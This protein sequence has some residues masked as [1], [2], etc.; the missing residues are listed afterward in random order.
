MKHIKFIAL[1][2][3]TLI[4]T[5]AFAAKQVVVYNWSE[6]IPEAVVEKFTEETGIKVIYS[7]YE[8][9]EVMYSKLQL[10]KNSG[11]DVIV[12]SAYYVSK[13]AKEKML[14]PLDKSKISHFK[15]L[16]PT[17]L[18][19]EFDP[20][21]QYSAPYLWGSTGIGVNSSEIDPATITSW[22]QL[23]DKK[24]AKQLLVTDDL[25]E[26]FH[27][28]LVLNGHSPN[29]T[30]PEEI[31]QAYELLKTLMPNVLTF[32]SDAPREP[33]LAGDV[34]LGMIWSGEAVMA[35]EEE[36]A[37]QY[38]YPSEGAIFWVDSFAIPAGAKNVDE[39]HAFID[40]MLRADN[41]AACVEEIGYATANKDALELVEEDTRNNPAIFPSEE[42]IKAGYF[43]NDVGD[44]VSI[45][46]QYWELL[47][48]G[49]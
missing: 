20:D 9:N 23:F 27:I 35:Q 43:Q 36:P 10:Q 12:P 28:A 17:L 41:A 40:F 37:I 26:V 48:V 15:Q 38:I 7:T 46:N 1:S 8:S 47:K 30:K 16:N 11:Y 49:N 4:A 22:K 32:N 5:Q 24:Y 29:T 44:A 34:S 45:Y 2:L 33:F 42:I 3:A 25:R 31:K 13:M 18:N 39:A 21:N 19:K 6:Y 14:L